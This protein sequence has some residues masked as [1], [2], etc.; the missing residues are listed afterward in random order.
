[1]SRR[2]GGRRRVTETLREK[3]SCLMSADALPYPGQC[4][5]TECAWKYVNAEQRESRM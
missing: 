3:L 5:M 1:M 2:L 4:H